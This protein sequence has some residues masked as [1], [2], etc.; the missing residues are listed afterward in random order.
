MRLRFTRR[1]SR[2]LAAIAEYIGKDNPIAAERVGV[3]IHTACA[4]LTEFPE[5]GRPG[6]R[7]N[8]REIS[9][10]GLPYIIVY[11]LVPDEIVVLGVYHERQLRPGQSEL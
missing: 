11:R 10:P 6:V 2:N 8:T 4:L 7:R 1:A 5:M 9:L 3:R